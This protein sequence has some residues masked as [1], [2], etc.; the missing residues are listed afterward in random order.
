MSWLTEFLLR[1]LGRGK[2][3]DLKET[4]SFKCIYYGRHNDVNI[5]FQF[6]L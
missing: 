5:L 4:Q 3:V 6:K 2:E 1:V